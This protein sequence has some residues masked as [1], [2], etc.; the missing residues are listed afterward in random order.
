MSITIRDMK[1]ED[2]DRIMQMV[3]CF[4]ASPAVEH[5]IPTSYFENAYTEMCNGGSQRLR[6]IAIE[7]EGVLAGYCQLSFS[8]STEAGGV[9]VLLEEMYM[10]SAFRG[11]GLGS[12]MFQFIKDEYRGKAARLRLEVARS[13]ARAIELYTRQGFE[14]LGYI[15]MINEDF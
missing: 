15:Q 13:N 12:A 9:V 8:Y 1:E 14:S 10:D 5:P 6:G 11:K 4:Y 3:E 7:W 2:R